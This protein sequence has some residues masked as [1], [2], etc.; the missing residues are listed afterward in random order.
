MA[1][2]HDTDNCKIGYWK[3][4]ISDNSISCNISTYTKI[5]QSIVCIFPYHCYSKV[6]FHS[7]DGNK[8]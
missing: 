2:C 6:R 5:L 7:F 1:W 4:V 3:F 8:P